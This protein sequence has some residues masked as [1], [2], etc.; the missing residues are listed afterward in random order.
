MSTTGDASG[1]TTAPAAS[2]VVAAPAPGT[3]FTLQ[4][5]QRA[6]WLRRFF[7]GHP[8]A[9]DAVVVAWFTVPSLLAAAFDPTP[10]RPVAL[11]VVL[12]LAGGAV[13]AARRRAPAAVAIALA[14][15]GSLTMVL[16]DA[17]TGFDLA[18]ALGLYAVASLR[19]GRVAWPVA[20]AGVGI[21]AIT[22]LAIG[23]REVLVPGA[24]LS[25]QGRVAEVTGILVFALAA[26]A[27]GTSVR[28]RR[29]HLADLVERAN[30]VARERDRQAQLALAGERTRIAREMHDVVAHSLSVMIALAD[31][32][33]AALERSPD[34]SRAALDELSETGRSAL[35]D[36]RRILGVLKDVDAPLEPQPGAVDLGALVERF[37]TAGLPVRT[38]GLGTPLPPDAGLQ[39]A[40]FRIVQESLTNALRHA[41]GTDRVDVSLCREE[42]DVVVEVIDA[43]PAVASDASRADTGGAG[44]GLIGMRE[45]AAVYGGRVEAGPHGA[46]WRVR[47]CLPWDGASRAST[48]TGPGVPTGTGTGTGT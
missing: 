32:A 40:V 27:I 8:G 48:T 29:V 17:L 2:P 41:P 5:A 47:A 30:A 19:P 24:P 46:G 23:D 13:L 36:M 38:T 34:R 26:M 7:L 4:G 45:R 12:V 37:R 18:L 9:M 6:G 15:L 20:G 21:M 11:T 3:L 25:P 43:G 16:T 33:S 14:L 1:P 22:I 44:Q 42:G 39:L 31:G 35:A 10:G 28:N